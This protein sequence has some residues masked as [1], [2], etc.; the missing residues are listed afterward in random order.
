M[1]VAVGSAVAVGAGVLVGRYTGVGGSG[2]K[3]VGV[4]VASPGACRNS[5]VAV[6]VISSWLREPATGIAARLWLAH[7]VRN[8][9]I[10][11]IIR[12]WLA[13]VFIER[14]V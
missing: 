12:I 8:E 5:D 11:T 9:Q 2:W 14:P 4:A 13:T 6:G 10:S 3:G 7:P 1:T